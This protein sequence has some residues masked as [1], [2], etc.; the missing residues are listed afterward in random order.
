MLES[1]AEGAKP[2]AAVRILGHGAH[3]AAA[4]IK[5][6]SNDNGS[7]SVRTMAEDADGL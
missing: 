7:G 5:G 3:R 2:E 1:A 6:R 4:I